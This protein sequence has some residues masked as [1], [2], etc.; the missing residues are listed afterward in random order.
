MIG[1]DKTA[2]RDTSPVPPKYKAKLH[3]ATGQFSFMEVEVEDT[4]PEIIKKSDWLLEVHKN[5]QK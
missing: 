4:I 3:I 1:T 5:K 2:M